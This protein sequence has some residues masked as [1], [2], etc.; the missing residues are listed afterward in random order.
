MPV[1]C[2][3]RYSLKPVVVVSGRRLRGVSE[4]WLCMPVF[5]PGPVVRLRFACTGGREG[6]AVSLAGAA[7]SIIFVAIKVSLSRQRFCRNK[8]MFVATDTC[9]SRQKWY[10]WQLP[11]MIGLGQ[12]NKC[13]S[14]AVHLID[15]SSKLTSKQSSRPVTSQSMTQYDFHPSNSQPI[16]Y[17]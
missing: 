2:L 4:I 13:F 5:C 17:Q 14:E 8:I 12:F 15:Q 16:S 7:T 11:P 1:L 6:W 9:L 3:Q 10:L